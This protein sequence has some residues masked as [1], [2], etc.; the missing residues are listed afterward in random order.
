VVRPGAQ[1]G[2]GVPREELRR[3]CLSRYFPGRRLGAI[4][5]ELERMRFCGLRPR[6]T[7]AH[8]A[9]GLV[10][11]KQDLTA[12]NSDFLLGQDMNHGVQRSPAAGR[13]V[14]FLDLC[15][16]PHAAFS[17]GEY[18]GK[19]MTTSQ[20]PPRWEPCARL[21]VDTSSRSSQHARIAFRPA[22]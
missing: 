8:E 19:P 9:A 1:L 7:H 17:G 10:L 3:D 2:Q 21:R 18:E 12:E 6:A 20:V 13:R 11:L 16:R 14:V 22:R 15:F 5:T 4:F